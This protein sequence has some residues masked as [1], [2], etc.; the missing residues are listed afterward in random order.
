MVKVNPSPKTTSKVRHRG[1]RLLRLAKHS[2]TSVTT[3]KGFDFEGLT[4]TLEP[5]LWE[6]SFNRL[7]KLSKLINRIIIE[8]YGKKPNLSSGVDRTLNEE[9][10]RKLFAAFT[11]EKYRLLFGLQLALA[12]RISEIAAL[13]IQDIDFNRRTATIY[14]EKTKKR[15]EKL[16]PLE[17]FNRL[18]AWIDLNKLQIRKSG[19]YVWFSEGNCQKKRQ[20]S[21]NT[22]DYLRKVFKEAVKRAGLDSIYAKSKDGNPLYRIATHSMRK[23]GITMMSRALNGDLF[24]LM[25]YSGHKD[26]KSLQSYVHVDKKNEVDPLID[27]VFSSKANLNELK[28]YFE[29]G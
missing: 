10:I 17:L 29:K 15:Y 26:M 25:A 22:K 7:K 14:E 1:V 21:H 4:R 3:S 9:E 13:N 27:R 23:T 28:K 20:C 18:I 8:K 19:G 5:I 11:S 12:L 6:L 24:K 2:L 16:I